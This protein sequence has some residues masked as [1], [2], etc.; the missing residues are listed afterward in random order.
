MSR[1]RESIDQKYA[2]E[3]I[4][5]MKNLLPKVK[6]GKVKIVSWGWWKGGTDGTYRLMIDWKVEE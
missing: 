6:F 1:I 4:S 2:S 5:F 3:V